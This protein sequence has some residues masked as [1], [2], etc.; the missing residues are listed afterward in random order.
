MIR[1]FTD[2]NAETISQYFPCYCNN[3]IGMPILA[4]QGFI[5]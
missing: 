1:L 5:M 4:Q 3:T 2:E